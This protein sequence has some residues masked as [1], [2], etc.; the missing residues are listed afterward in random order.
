MTTNR[1]IQPLVPVEEMDRVKVTTPREARIGMV[2]GWFG[3]VLLVAGSL[4]VLHGSTLAQVAGVLDV[5]LALW[6]LIGRH[7]VGAVQR[8]RP[9]SRT[10]TV[11]VIEPGQ[12]ERA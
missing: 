11:P 4:G 8:R 12:A 7:A 1:R 5:T 9:G 10:L 2:A 6:L 3:L